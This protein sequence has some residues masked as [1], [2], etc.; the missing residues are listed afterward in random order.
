MKKLKIE[1]FRLGEKV[2]TK[3]ISLPLAAL[4]ISLTLVPQKIKSSLEN[5]GVDLTSCSELIRE[6][7]VRGM[8]IEIENSREKL[9]VSVEGNNS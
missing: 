7:D 4:H 1:V 8:L 2:P 5:E 3:T 6:R 9:V